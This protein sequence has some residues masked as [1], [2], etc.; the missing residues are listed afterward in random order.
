MLR[1]KL[2]EGDETQDLVRDIEGAQQDLKHL[3]DDLQDYATP[4]KLEPSRRDVREIIA[5]VW[6]SLRHEHQGRD[7]SLRQEVQ[8]VET[9]CDVDASRLAQVFRNVLEN[10]L[11]VC[12]EPALIEV[13]FADVLVGGTSMLRIAIR[14][15]GPGIDSRQREQIFTPFYTTKSHGSGLGMAIA[16]Q[17]VEAHGGR[18]GVAVRDG[19]GAE[20]LI[21]LPRKRIG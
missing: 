5:N 2:E 12:R 17:V 21:D 15:N 6:G 4:R 3:L 9:R 16:R 7:M 10:A 1:W 20:I 14:D 13:S 8:L 11:S 19:P 18:I